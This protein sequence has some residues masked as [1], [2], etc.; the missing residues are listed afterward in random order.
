MAT[1]MTADDMNA[2]IELHD[3]TVEGITLR[4]GSGIVRFR[5]AYV[6]R[7]EGRPC[8]D[9]GYGFL[10]DLDLVVTEA[11]LE[12]TF[13]KMPCWISDGLLSVGKEVLDNEIP[14]PFNKRG[15]VYLSA[16]S[17]NGEWLVIRGTSATVVLVG[18]ARYLER[19]P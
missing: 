9:P 7:S 13:T 14:L 11:V 4:D 6:H 18:E 15:E 10:Q 16:V 1:D 5:P 12:S 3:S 17:V 19:V 2:L 8:I